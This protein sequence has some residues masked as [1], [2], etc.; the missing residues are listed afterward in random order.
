MSED[1]PY[2]YEFG[3]FRLDAARR[4]L[5]RRGGDDQPVKL[6]SKAFDTLLYM[7]RH[8]GTVLDKDELL[9]AVWP[10]VIVEENTLSQNISALRRALGEKQGE[11]RYIVTVPG[12]GFSFVATVTAHSGGD[13]PP[14]IEGEL[15]EPKGKEVSN[16]LAPGLHQ[17]AWK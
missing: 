14:V 17:S 4:L 10:D 2:I 12:R 13:T 7:V 5:L 11:N 16:S 8:R 1:N 15:P 3:D 6:T 9:R